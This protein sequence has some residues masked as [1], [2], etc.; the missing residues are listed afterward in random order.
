M[1]IDFGIKSFAES[2]GIRVVAWRDVSALAP[3]REPEMKLIKKMK[4][5]PIHERGT[6]RLIIRSEKDGRSKYALKALHHPPVISAI[7]GET[8]KVQHLSSA[9]EMDGTALL[10]KGESGYPNGNEPILAEGQAIIWVGDDVKEKASIAAFVQNLVLRKGAKGKPAQHKRPGIEGDFLRMAI[11]VFPNA[12]DQLKLPE[13]VFRDSESRQDLAY[14]GKR[15]T[16]YVRVRMEWFWSGRH[17]IERAIEQGTLPRTAGG[18]DFGDRTKNVLKTAQ[19]RE[20]GLA[21]ERKQMPRL[22]GM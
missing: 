5:R 20:T 18:T 1:L 15:R 12:L 22:R 8:K 6:L 2:H 16:R 11:T 3:F 19:L 17:K 7:F 4:A 21:C 14:R 13:L 9:S 10:P